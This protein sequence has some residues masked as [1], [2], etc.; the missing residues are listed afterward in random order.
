MRGIVLCALLVG[1]GFRAPE[2]DGDADGD[3]DGGDASTDAGDTDDAPPPDMGPPCATFSTV[4]DTCAV[5]SGSTTPLMFVNATT[6]DTATGVI[7]REPADAGFT[8]TS[9]VVNTPDGT[10]RAIVASDVTFAPGATL[11]A[12]GVLPLAIVAHGAFTMAAD[13]VIDVGAG[14]AGARTSCAGPAAPGIDNPGGASGGGGGGFAAMGG[15]GGESDSDGARVAGGA[16]GAMEGLPTSLRGGCGGA[17]GGAGVNGTNPGGGGGAGGGAVYVV[18]AGALTLDPDAVIDAGGAGGGGGSRDNSFGD[19]GGGGGGAGGMIFLEGPTITGGILVANGGGGGEGSGDG[20]PGN[21]GSPGRRDEDAA[22][23]GRGQS[24]TG[25][26][27][28]DGGH[29]GVAEGRSPGRAQAGG[30]GG[31]GGAA[32]YIRLLADG[33]ASPSLVSPAAQ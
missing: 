30:S 14:G 17:S 2:A 26:D 8:V 25:T 23:G 10:V 9:Q 11:I 13:A 4:L 22:N 5:T 7:M 24:P 19:A 1:C 20:D 33:E 18:A 32:G 3:A 15:A 21:P 28:G 16:G 6:F 12:I 31:G 27:G 29:L